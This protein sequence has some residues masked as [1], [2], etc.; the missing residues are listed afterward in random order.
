[1]EEVGDEVLRQVQQPIRASQRELER[2]LPGA[3]LTQPRMNPTF[4]QEASGTTFN[5]NISALKMTGSTEF[6][7][8]FL[9]EH[10]LESR[11]SMVMGLGADSSLSGLL[12]VL[13]LGAL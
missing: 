13:D 4:S 11:D 8:L 9:P 10:S 6:L 7:P 2:T 1:M 12:E 5:G 3:Q